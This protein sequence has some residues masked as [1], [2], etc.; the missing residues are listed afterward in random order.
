M[1]GEPSKKSTDKCNKYNNMEIDDACNGTSFS[2]PHAER[3][4]H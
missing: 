2:V 1:A 3:G 4:K